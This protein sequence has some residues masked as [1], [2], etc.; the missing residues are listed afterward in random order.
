MRNKA[1]YWDGVYDRWE[2]TL[3]KNPDDP[4]T[5]VSAKTVMSMARKE[6]AKYRAQASSMI[7]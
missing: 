2:D 5:K 6:A 3:A 4:M 1:A 7:G